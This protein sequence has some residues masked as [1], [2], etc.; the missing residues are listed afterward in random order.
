MGK[1]GGDRS[2]LAF[3]P[4]PHRE[5]LVAIIRE[6]EALAG[7]RGGDA[8][9]A[10]SAEASR[11]ADERA[12]D[13]ILRRHP[14]DG[15]GFF[16]RAEIIAG[17]RAFAAEESFAIDER[18]FVARIRRRPVRSQSGVTPLTVLT[19]PFPCPGRCVY[20]PND[21]RMPKS[22]LADEP[23]A[24]R[25]AN[26]R[27]D[28]YLQTWNRLAAFHA[29]GHSTEKIELIV[30]GGTW[31]FYPEAYQVWFV[32]RCFDAM[33]DFGAE[34]DGRE[35]AVP[36]QVDYDAFEASAPEGIRTGPLYNQVVQQQL[37]E[38]GAGAEGSAAA[39]AEQGERATW[40]ELEASQKRN[41]D[42]VCRNVGFSVET[43]PDHV[44]E[45]EVLRIRRLGCTKV[46]LGI[47][48]VSDTVLDAIDR[49]HDVRDTRVA[50]ARLRRA[51]FKI[52]AHWMPNLLAS[53]PE[54]DCEDFDRLF[55]DPD[56]RPDELKVYP[57]SLIETAELMRHYEAGEWR[58]YEHD[59]LLGVLTHALERAPRYCRLTRVIRDISSDDIVVGNKLTNFR[60]LAERALAER[61][62]R[63][64]EIRVREI[65]RDDFVSDAVELRATTYASGNSEDAFIEFTTPGDQ[66]VGFLRLCFPK[67]EG[68]CD[69]ITASALIREVH[70]YGGALDLGARGRGHAQHQGFGTRL[71]EEARRLAKERGYRTLSVISAV[72]TRGWYRKLGFRDGTLYQHADL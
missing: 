3:D 66:I 17:Y 8:T 18:S 13:A 42:A 37:R 47:Q 62:G 20:C 63:C 11:A 43:R 46:Q 68:F 29:T 31:S 33:N 10:T 15:R 50:M 27:F 57:C 16:S 36:A 38:Q 53:T 49:G 40:E 71:I 1:K 25:A 14:R 45:A 41:E 58:P 23:G 4:V 48:S 34:I 52:H 5:P 6:I 9:G 35:D 64:E 65:R 19:K 12:F 30:L 21:L 28:P 26:N 39:N 44:S 55:D 60:E 51:G 32:K 56:F 24:Q 67:D 70:V 72:G 2:H 7:L 59:E 61:G 22:Y 69:E 54:R